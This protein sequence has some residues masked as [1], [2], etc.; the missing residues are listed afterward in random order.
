ML[1]VLLI[2][3]LFFVP[4]FA[5]LKFSAERSDSNVDLFFI[6]TLRPIRIIWGKLSAA[7]VLMLL[8]FSASMPFIGK[9]VDKKN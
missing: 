8:S 1:T 3:C 9:L 5:A 2:A 6:T 4:A 7:L